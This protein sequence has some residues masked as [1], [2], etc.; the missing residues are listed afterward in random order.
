MYVRNENFYSDIRLIFFWKF[1]WELVSEPPMLRLYVS[2]YSIETQKSVLLMTI[3]NRM[4]H[5]Y[6]LGNNNEVWIKKK[7]LNGYV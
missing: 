3:S 1:L 5:L 6:D 2:L 4:Q 7:T